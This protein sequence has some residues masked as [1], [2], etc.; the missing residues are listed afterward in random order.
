MSQFKLFKEIKELSQSKEWENARL[1]WKEIDRYMLGDEFSW[2]AKTCLCGHTPIKEICVI[3]NLRNN[4]HAEVGNCCIE[5]I[6]GE[7]KNYYFGSL[8]RIKEDIN[9]SIGKKTLQFLFHEGVLNTW[10]YS[11]YLSIQKKRKLSDKQNKIKIKIN[12][13]VLVW[14]SNTQKKYFTNSIRK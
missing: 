4:E 11:F 2:E 7:N 13:N 8:K 10:E 6:T 1:E 9:K 12:L 14:H 5:L 3:K